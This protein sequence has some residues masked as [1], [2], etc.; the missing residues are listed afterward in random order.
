MRDIEREE[1][2]KILV[3]SFYGQV[4]QDELL[5]PVFNDFAQVNWETHLPVMYNF[6]STVLFGSMAYKG[7]PFPK[8]LRLPVKEQH[9]ERWVELFVSTVDALYKG[10]KAE[11]IK[12]KAQ[13][14][15]RIFQ[16]KMGI[17]AV[18]V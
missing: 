8:H 12:F 3:D 17:L 13:N 9:F 16:L 1:D 6:W 10:E 5:A 11:D 7:Q 18:Q 2:I 14:I 15:A 4:N